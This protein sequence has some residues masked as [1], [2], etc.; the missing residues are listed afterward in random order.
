M[1][2][3]EKLVRFGD[4][5][6]LS[7]MLTAPTRT[8]PQAPGLLLFNAGIVHRIGPHRLNVKI[9]R[10]L[11][12]NGVAALRFDLSGLGDSAPAPNGAGLQAQTLADIGAALDL[13]SAESGAQRHLLVGLCSGADDGYRAALADPRIAGLVLLDPYAYENRRAKFERTAQKA[14]DPDRWKSALARIGRAPAPKVEAR[15]DDG[16]PHPPP[17][18]FGADLKTL[19]DRGVA[20][21]ILYSRFTE[22]QLTRPEHFFDTFAAFDLRGRAEVEI[23]RAVD[24][25]YTELMAQQ[26]LI[27]RIEDFA[28]S[29]SRA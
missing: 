15:G 6:R 8:D 7:G 17:A 14:L 18:E 11:A 27:A 3:R 22:E 19:A 28:R 26:A 24:H 21:L 2:F 4:G 20:I 23:N 9:A 25:T 12:E 29:L 16:R 10:A 13:L 5:A 1:S